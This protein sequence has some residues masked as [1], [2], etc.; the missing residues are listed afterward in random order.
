MRSRPIT[1]CLHTLWSGAALLALAAC[2]GGLYLNYGFGSDGDRAPDVSLAVSPDAASR[3]QTVQLVAAASDDF[4]VARVD[5]YR[6]DG[7]VATLQG[8]DRS[9]PYQLNT[10]VPASAG[11]SLQFYAR[12]TDDAGQSRDS[13]LVSITISP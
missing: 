5:F 6:V 8:S 7:A 11:S 4:G 1:A 3:G 2:G 9:A 13:A 12:A 10:I